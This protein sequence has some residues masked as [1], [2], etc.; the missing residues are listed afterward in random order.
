MRADKRHQVEDV[1]KS[2]LISSEHETD[3]PSLSFQYQLN[4]KK[5]DEEIRQ[6]TSELTAIRMDLIKTIIFAGIAIGIELVLY[7][8]LHGK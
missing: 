8:Q 6:Q 4:P 2:A 3:V 5:R 1:K 7:W